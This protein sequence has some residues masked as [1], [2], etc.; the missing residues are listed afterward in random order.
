MLRLRRLLPNDDRQD[1]TFEKRARCWRS[2]V[3][4]GVLVAA[5]FTPWADLR[6]ADADEEKSSLNRAQQ[7]LSR[8]FAGVTA[9]EGRF[10]Y[11]S[12]GAQTGGDFNKFS[13]QQEG[14]TS[15]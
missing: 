1:R 6:S 3:A 10:T 9:W 2:V 11:E 14:A 13:Y 5:M 15:G 4:F 12:Y 8:K 7:E